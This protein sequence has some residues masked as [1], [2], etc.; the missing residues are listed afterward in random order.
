[1]KNDRMLDVDVTAPATRCRD[2][3]P[4]PRESCPSCGEAL[5]S[6]AAVQA[7]LLR[8]GG[9]GEAQRSTL[10]YCPSCRWTLDASKTSEKP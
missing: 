6:T 10:V 2:L 5:E 7:P 1:V 3:V 8:H 4:L 9:Y